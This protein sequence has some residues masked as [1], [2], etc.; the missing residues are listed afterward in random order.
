MLQTV[1]FF[2]EDFLEEVNVLSLL[3]LFVLLS[4]GFAA[5]HLSQNLSK[6][7]FSSSKVREPLRLSFFNEMF[8]YQIS[9][10]LSSQLDIIISFEL[11]LSLEE[12][13]VALFEE[14]LEVRMFEGLQG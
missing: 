14:L 6:A 9:I 5:V 4:T 2:A 12:L 8:E 1:L 3:A 13:E 7:V 10:G 11:D